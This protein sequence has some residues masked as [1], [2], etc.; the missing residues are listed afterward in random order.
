MCTRT[1]TRL[2]WTDLC[3]VRGG[4]GGGAEQDSPAWV[5]G[6][7]PSQRH[8]KTGHTELSLEAREL[9]RALSRTMSLVLVVVKTLSTPL[10][11][12]CFDSWFG[13]TA[14]RAYA[15]SSTPE[16][17]GPHVFNYRSSQRE[18]RRGTAAHPGTQHQPPDGRDSRTS[19]TRRTIRAAGTK[20]A[21][22]RRR[23]STPAPAEDARVHH[24][25][26]SATT[27]PSTTGQAQPL[28]P[29]SAEHLGIP[30]TSPFS[31]V[32]LTQ[33]CCQFPFSAGSRAGPGIQSPRPCPE[34]H[35][36][37]PGRRPTPRH[38]GDRA[39]RPCSLTG[40]RSSRG[41]R[42]IARKGCAASDTP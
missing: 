25:G 28:P 29:R 41:S 10:H 15:T 6:F 23:R 21:L 39:S 31:P 33:S 20:G 1:R 18:P 26:S 12:P 37:L 13:Y 4:A 14:P 16:A 8:A 40:I 35:P 27:F 34:L 19:M 42:R 22:T 2:R 3:V 36:L 24:R 32:V 5:K 30:R 9:G 7:E 17:T 11:P 38:T